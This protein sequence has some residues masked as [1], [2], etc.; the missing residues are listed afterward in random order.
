MC[1]WGRSILPVNCDERGWPQVVSWESQVGYE[2][3]SLFQK[4]CTDTDCPGGGGVTVPGGVPDLWRCGTEGH[5][6]WAWWSG[7]ELDL[8]ILEAFSNLSDSVT[9]GDLGLPEEYDD[10]LNLL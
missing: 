1:W 2:E 5:G 9:R 4:M 10:G 6:Q 3:K 7:L 8:V